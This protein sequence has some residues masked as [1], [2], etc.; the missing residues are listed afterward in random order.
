MKVFLALDKRMNHIRSM[1]DSKKEGK[2]RRYCRYCGKRLPVDVI[3]SG[4]GMVIE[5]FCKHCKRKNEIT[6]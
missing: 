1:E 3:R 2:E 4:E 6:E 5:V